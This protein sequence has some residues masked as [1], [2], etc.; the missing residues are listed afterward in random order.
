[1]RKFLILAAAAAAAAGALTLPGLA[2]AADLSGAWKLT[3]DVGGMT[4]HVACD[5]KQAGADLG[6]T[7]NRT[8]ADNVEKP[9]PI[10]GKVDGSTATWSY[11]VS[12]GDMPLKVDYTGTASSDTAMTGKISVAGMDGTFTGTKG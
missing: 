8:D 11:S 7:C 2:S 4:V 3:V 5:L 1:M 10:T 6:G 9:T 12:F